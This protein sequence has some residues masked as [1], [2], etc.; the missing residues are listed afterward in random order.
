MVGRLA[1]RCSSSRGYRN[2][3]GTEKRAS[4]VQKIKRQAGPWPIHRYQL[5]LAGQG[6]VG[7]LQFRSA[8]SD[9]GGDTIAGWH[10]FDQR[11]VWRDHGN[12]ARHQRRDA[13]IAASFHRERVEHLVTAQPR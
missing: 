10:L 9:I 12:A 6:N 1:S 2:I 13:D 3:R 5:A 11:A 7:G 8:K 4:L